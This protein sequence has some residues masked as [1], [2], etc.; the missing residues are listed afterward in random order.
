MLSSIC[1]KYLFQNYEQAELKRKPCGIVDFVNL[2][3]G[4]K[5]VITI[6]IRGYASRFLKTA[7]N[8]LSQGR[9][10]ESIL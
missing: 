4:L 8:S 9:R 6:R 1:G 3:N 5:P 7:G 10:L 2:Y